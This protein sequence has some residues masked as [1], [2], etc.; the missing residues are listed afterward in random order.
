MFGWTIF[1]IF[2]FFANKNLKKIIWI[3]LKLF[4]GCCKRI[5]YFS[6]KVSLPPRGV[7]YYPNNLDH[8]TDPKNSEYPNTKN[9][10]L[11]P[12]SNKNTENTKL[13]NTNDPVEYAT[14][15]K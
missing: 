13:C 8:E 7:F 15:W 14:G 2:F 3:F 5:F 9:Q 11:S 12:K 4:F 6:S 10:Q 1:K